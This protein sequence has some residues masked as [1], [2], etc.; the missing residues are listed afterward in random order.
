VSNDP[1]RAG[2]CCAQP[3]KGLTRLTFSDGTHVQVNGLD[4]ILAAMH[5]VGRQV[6]TDTAAEI[7]KRLRQKNYIP[8]S[9]RLEYEGLVLR[10][11]KKFVEDRTDCSGK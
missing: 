1:D 3:I 8:S 10:E 2:S 11:Y 5:T 6:N 9:D 7:V 4:Q